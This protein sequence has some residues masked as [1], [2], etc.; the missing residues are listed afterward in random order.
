MRRYLVVG[1]MAAGLFLSGVVVAV[2]LLEFHQFDEIGRTVAI[3]GLV[4]VSVTMMLA[5]VTMGR[6]LGEG[7]SRAR[8]VENEAMPGVGSQ[9]RIER[10]ERSGVAEADLD[11][12]RPLP[13]K[14]ATEVSAASRGGSYNSK[15]EA[16]EALTAS[17]PG[18][19]SVEHPK[20]GQ[21]KPP[22][23][24]G[25]SVADPPELEP[26]GEEPSRGGAPEEIGPEAKAAPQTSDL[27]SRRDSVI[28]AWQQYLRGGDGHFNTDGLR[29]QL[30]ASGLELSVRTGESVGA[31]DN[32]L[33][34]EDPG[35]SARRF[36]VVPNFTKSPRAAPDWF[37]DVGDGV[38]TRRTRT[39]HR[40]AEG[41]WTES[42]FDVVEKGSIA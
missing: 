11:S 19:C 20:D 39:I 12:E 8:S 36:L 17:A 3:A 29:E 31:A 7:A 4:V 28:G 15:E 9:R 1:M 30:K 5:F 14:S 34:V 40:L 16:G 35:H 6:R 41:Q 2:V 32:V 18:P 10:T 24:L 22:E 25:D 33:L 23:A 42:G 37:D 26:D 21:N 27:G 13:A 38:L